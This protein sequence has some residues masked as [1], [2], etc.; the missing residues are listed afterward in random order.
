MTIKAIAIKGAN[1][2]KVGEFTYTVGTENPPQDVTVSNPVASP[3]AGAVAKGTKIS[4]TSA[5]EEAKIYYTTDKTEPTKES[6][7]YK[8]P[9]LVTE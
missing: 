7:L 3:V 2:S 1:S 6:E 4:L 5:T 8:E 9:I